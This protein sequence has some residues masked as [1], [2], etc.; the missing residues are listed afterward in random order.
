MNQ[1]LQQIIQNGISEAVAIKKL[2]SDGFNEL[3]S[4][5]ERKIFEII[6]SVLK[7]PMLALLVGAGIIYLILGEPKDALL[8]SSFIFFTVGITIY[9][10]RKTEK[11]IRALKRLS[12][13]RALVVRD[14]K[15][16][17]IPGREVVNQDTVIIREGDRIPADAYVIRQN[18]LI[19]DE[20][21]LTGESRAVTKSEWNGN[22]INIRPGG[23]NL[24][25]VYSGTLVV[26][27]NATIWVY[28]IGANTQMG[29]IGKSLNVIIDEATLIQKETQKIVK[30]FTITGGILCILLII[31][32]GITKGNWL[33][34]ILA[35]LSLSMSMLPEEFPV[36][37][38]IF[39]ALGAW[40]LSKRQVLVRHVP[41]VE[42]LGAATVL[43][44][45]KTGTLTANKMELTEL[46]TISSGKYY[47]P[48]NPIL[49]DK[50]NLELLKS[51]L[52]SSDIDAYDVLDKEIK[53]LG[54]KVIPDV[55]KFRNNLE[56]IKEYPMNKQYRGVTYV[57]QEKNANK[58]IATKGAPED[59]I[60]IC[61][62]SST[63]K[64]V[65][66]QIILDMTDRGLRVLGVATCN[67]TSD[68]LE[69]DQISYPFKFVGLLGFSDPIRPQI[70][71]AVLECYQAGIRVI[72][73][74]GDY[75]GTAK[76]IAKKIGLINSDSFITGSE[77]AVMDQK[78][79]Q[80]KIKTINIFARVLPE[81]KL[82]IVNALKANKDIVA[83]TGDGVNDAPALK[84]A[85]IGISMGERGTDVA[86]EAS[87]IVLL[88]DDFSSIVK[89]V[90][91]GRKI[92]E[93]L[94]KAMS[95][96]FAVHFPIAGLTIF[97]VIFGTPVILFPA[98]IA[99]LE[100]IIDPACSI[101]FESEHSEA[102]IMREP[103]RNLKESVFGKKLLVIST[104]QGIS[105]LAITYILYL[106]SL[107]GNKSPDETRTIVFTALVSA[108]LALIVT[109]LSWRRL[110][111]RILTRASN[112]LKI[113]LSLVTITL[114]SSIYIPLF[115]SVFRFSQLKLSD[116]FVAIIAGGISLGW[117][118]LFKLL[119]KKA[120]R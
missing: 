87:D 45:D 38:T 22:D 101:V 52:L 67:Y 3:P 64:N 40:R 81:Q 4:A 41:V 6:F 70:A 105:V 92:Y 19:I 61:Q 57:W 98:H 89:A 43:C 21:I 97:P 76:S 118:E 25:I 120:K 112:A 46:F 62:L 42:T 96:I 35:G 117:F 79:L 65:L 16:L 91:T 8:L 20:S 83:M 115:R 18:N 78:D 86:R 73:I 93:N 82:L 10:E 50:P 109:N 56:K 13:P 104:M 85:H 1:K 36:V 75:P 88:N 14:G 51:G 116:I 74:T 90:K 12:S 80:E 110:G 95:Y 69:F 28:A 33:E 63:E 54:E 103:P 37:L 27:G 31:I 108:N 60:N 72:M 102:G 30:I 113:I 11:A 71:D 58:I 99:F 107:S 23:D 119:D 29:S 24:P 9:Q 5:R 66:N 114:V 49:P 55:C 2:K 68:R 77:L 44:V 26:S 94:K 7:E 84:S 17:R 32:W 34:G 111:I 48:S 59:V 47:P 100:L 53:R 106:F 15:E 39:F